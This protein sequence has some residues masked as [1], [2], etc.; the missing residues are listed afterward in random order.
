MV[1]DSIIQWESWSEEIRRRKV[2][3]SHGVHQP[4]ERDCSIP[5]L[6]IQIVCKAMYDCLFF[7]ACSTDP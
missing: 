5:E 4:V 1:F 3:S 7:V 2:S 6:E